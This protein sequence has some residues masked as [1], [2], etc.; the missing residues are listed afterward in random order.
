LLNQVL[1][2]GLAD[3]CLRCLWVDGA[4]LPGQGRKLEFE[5][6]QTVKFAVVW[7]SGPGP[8]K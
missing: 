7:L 2:A 8:A 5:A 4:P 1:I 6:P 3:A